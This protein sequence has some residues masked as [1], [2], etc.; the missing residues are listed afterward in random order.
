MST[1]QSK[2]G[3]E[4]EVQPQCE[5]HA[6]SP[7]CDNCGQ[8]PAYHQRETRDISPTDRG[9]EVREYT[10]NF[11]DDCATELG[12]ICPTCGYTDPEW[13]GETACSDDWHYKRYFGRPYEGEMLT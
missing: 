1:Q 9:D 13:R 2:D 12:L 5:P 6:N 11:C 8:Q 3:V 10:E 4:Q 7:R